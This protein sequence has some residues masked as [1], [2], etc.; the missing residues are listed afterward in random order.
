MSDMIVVVRIDN[1]N[2]KGEF[3]LVDFILK[4]E[5]NLVEITSVDE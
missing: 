5:T 2:K 4:K 3:K 1:F